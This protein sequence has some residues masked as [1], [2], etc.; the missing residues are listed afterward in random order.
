MRSNPRL[1]GSPAAGSCRASSA[2]RCASGRSPP[3]RAPCRRG[4]D[5]CAQFGRARAELGGAGL[6]PAADGAGRGDG[7]GGQGGDDPEGQ[8]ACPAA[9]DQGPGDGGLQVVALGPDT[10]LPLQLRWAAEFGPG[11]FGE[12]RIVLGVRALQPVWLSGIS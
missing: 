4:Q 7:E 2:H 11:P 3:V 8:R 5:R 6:G 1:T 12:R 10:R 9:A